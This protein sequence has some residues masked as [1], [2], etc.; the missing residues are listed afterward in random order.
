MWTF[1]G[2]ISTQKAYI[3]ALADDFTVLSNKIYSTA[4]SINLAKG[5]GQGN[6]YFTCKLGTLKT[7]LIKV[8]DDSYTFVWEKVLE[9]SGGGSPSG[10]FSPVSVASSTS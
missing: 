10:Y 1:G 9:A 6:T 3:V 5:D 8:N 2:T 7:I 4:A